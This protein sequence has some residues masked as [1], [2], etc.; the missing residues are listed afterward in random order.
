VII[1]D[2]FNLEEDINNFY[3]FSMLLDTLNRAIL[4]GNTDKDTISNGLIG[5]NTMLDLH[6]EKTFN[7]F[8][9]VHGLNN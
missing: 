6:I 3:T 9:Q 5:I 7:T 2:R 8:R 1:M 4:E